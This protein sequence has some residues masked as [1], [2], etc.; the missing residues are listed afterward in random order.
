MAQSARQIPGHSGLNCFN[1]QWRERSEWCV[2]DDSDVAVL[3]ASKVVSNYTPGQLL[4]MQGDPCHGVFSVVKGTI[5]IRKSDPAGNTVLVRLRHAGETIGYRDFFSGSDYTTSAEVLTEATVCFVQRDAVEV[6]L[7]RNPSLGLNFL[8]LLG[9]D[10]KD[11]ED[12]ILRT[13]RLPIRA[14]LAH[15][16]LTLKNRY[17][18][19]LDDGSMALKLP[20]SRQDMADILGA[21][22]ETI[23]RT[24]HRMEIDN[25]A[26]FSGRNV[27]IP[28]LDN[29][30]D[31]IE[32]PED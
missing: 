13:T 28:D 8:N 14:R 27:V 9:D 1:C 24:I 31:E 29:L 23:A 17:A 32:E 26:R 10:L 30:L 15:L 21:R 12:A 19:V 3:D 18:E 6:L 25:V 4:F 11:A 7:N 20:M 16:L 22:P 2:L 5:A